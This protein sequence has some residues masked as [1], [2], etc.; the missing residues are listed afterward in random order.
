VVAHLEQRVLLVPKVQPDKLVKPE[1]QVVKAIQA[2]Q[3]PP[4]PQ[5]KL[6]QQEVLEQMGRLVLQVV[7]DYRVSKASPVLPELLV[8]QDQVV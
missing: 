7:K 6:E 2:N 3:V 5:D 8:Q 1:L 4:A